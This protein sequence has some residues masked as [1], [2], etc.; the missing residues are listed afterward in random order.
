MFFKKGVTA[1]S[2]I[3]ENIISFTLAIVKYFNNKEKIILQLSVRYMGVTVIK[4]IIMDF[5]NCIIEKL[6]RIARRLLIFKQKQEEAEY[7]NWCMVVC[8]E[9]LFLEI[10]KKKKIRGGLL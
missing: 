2:I 10:V 7:R 1:L 4:N 8:K 6:S 5:M 9:H 3:E